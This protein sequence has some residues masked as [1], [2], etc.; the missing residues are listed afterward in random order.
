[1]TELVLCHSEATYT[2]SEKY[3]YPFYF[4]WHC[5]TKVRRLQAFFEFSDRVLCRKTRSAILSRWRSP[6]GDYFR[7]R[8]G[9]GLVFELIWREPAN[10]WYIQQIY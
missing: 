6:E 5:E 2:L 1:M 8:T 3:L 7:V 4:A 9:E 10:R